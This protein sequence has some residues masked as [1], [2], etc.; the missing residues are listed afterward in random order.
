M[1]EFSLVTKTSLYTSFILMEVGNLF[2]QFKFRR[3]K[4]EY[5]QQRPSSDHECEADVSSQDILC[6]YKQIYVHIYFLLFFLFAEVTRY[7]NHLSFF[8]FCTLFHCMNV[9]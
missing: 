4:R 1:K 6:K 5:T 9:P 3:Y 8:I 7:Y 2:T